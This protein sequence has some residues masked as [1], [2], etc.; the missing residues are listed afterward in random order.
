MSKEILLAKIKLNEFL[1]N[2]KGLA[3]SSS[4]IELGNFNN[5]STDSRKINKGDIFIALDG[6]NFRGHNFISEA[7][8]NGAEFCISTKKSNAPKQIIVNSTLDFIQ[9]FA[10]YLIKS[11]SKLKTYG[12]TG[13]NG[14]TSTKEILRN[15]MSKQFNVL[16]THANLN[17]QIGLPLTIF[18]LSNKHQVLILEMGTNSKGEIKNLAK[19]AKP[20]FATITNI[21]KGH[22]EGLIDKKN[23]FL[24]KSD[25]TNYFH[26]K[27]AFS[28]NLDDEFMNNFYSKLNCRKISYGITNS[29]DVTAQ[30]IQ[31]D[32]SSF[33]LKYRDSNYPVKL[34]APGINNIYNSLCSAALAIIAN[35]EIESIISGI[36]SFEG[37]ENRFRI[38]NLKKGNVIINDTY[39]ANP[40]STVRAIEMV[41]EM[42][43]EK[44]K[45]AILGSMLELGETSGL[46]H[47][48][49]SEQ[50]K[51]NNFNELFSYGNNAAD[52]SKNLDSNTT[53]VALEN[54][55]DIKKHINLNSIDNTVILV[56]GSRGMKMEQIFS[57]LDL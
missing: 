6:E 4:N 51:L 22:T 55:S 13:T 29:A 37:I 54:H 39:N 15:I 8:G 45:I 31:N 50:I 19:I 2:Y 49:I 34:K 28:F 20:N 40:D 14:K 7:L 44:K 33:N 10:G 56:K 36:N 9:D 47:Q 38:I 11:N 41:K 32:F 16:A 1:K 27:S 25:I 46:E 5:I 3:Y 57:S 43:P 35:V 52:Y 21:G 53:F 23:I 18:N 24:E 12:I 48:A 17:N 42:F 30:N 26:S